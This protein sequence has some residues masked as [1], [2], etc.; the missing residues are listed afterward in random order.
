M[1]FFDELKRR[2]VFKVGIAY[3]IVGWLL[4]QVGVALFPTFGAPSWVLKAYS[5]VVLL[6][7]PIAL[8]LAWAF[9]VT[10]DGI[11]R[12]KDVSPNQSQSKIMGKKLEYFIIIMLLVTAGYF[13]WESRFSSEDGQPIVAISEAKASIAVL[14]FVNMSSDPEQEFF[15]D[16]IT[17]EI[18]NALVKVNGLKV[19][20]RT[21][22]FA[23]KGQNV[24]LRTVGDELGVDNIVEGSIR[25]SGNRLRITAQLINTS[26]GSHLWSEVYDRE[27]TDVFL[28]Q[29]EIARSIAA[30]LALSLGI[31]EGESLV[32]N[33]VEDMEAYDMYLRANSLLKARGLGLAEAIELYNNV[34]EREPNYAPAWAGLAQAWNVAPT[35]LDKYS[36]P[37]ETAAARARAGFAAERAVSLDDENVVGISALATWQ[38]DRLNWHEA[39]QLFL[40]A[41]TIDPDNTLVLE[42]YS[43]F[44]EFVGQ[45]AK[46]LEMTQRM[47]DLDKTVPLFAFRLANSLLVNGWDEEALNVYTKLRTQDPEFTLSHINGVTAFIGSAHIEDAKIYFEESKAM[48]FNYSQLQLEQINWMFAPDP[49]NQ[50]VLDYGANNFG[51]FILSLVENV[52]GYFKWRNEGIARRSYALWETFDPT[53]SYTYNDHR[54]KTLLNDLKLT[55]YFWTTG[56]WPDACR[57]ISE[58]DF[59]CGVFDKDE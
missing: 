15:S 21:S 52:D 50:P 18:L 34:I 10:D 59:E 4:I 22:A 6:G 28:I 24:D 38:R 49:K 16:G 9:E 43:E 19:T 47:Y 33:R 46:A 30:A 31:K 48:G 3:A 1:N 7:F 23:Y 36:L 39:E 27:L 41:I 57:P 40:R 35:Y 58:D 13:I 17:E 11:K 29:D 45:M 32:S 12:S 44:L 25:K 53:N 42:D 5:A 37:I 56:S 14:P 20:A 54:F 8:L 2:N 26:D 51:A 55:E